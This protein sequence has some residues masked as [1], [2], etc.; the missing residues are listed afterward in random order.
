MGKDEFTPDPPVADKFCR[1]CGKWKAFTE[2][3]KRGGKSAYLAAY[4]K[5]CHLKPFEYERIICPHCKEKIAFFGFD[6]KHNVVA[7]KSDILKRLRKEAKKKEKK[8]DKEKLKKLTLK[9]ALE[10][11]G[12]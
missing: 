5:D 1:R 4:C 8:V 12:A 11:D 3:Y 7:Q 6:S 2:F 10:D 9:E